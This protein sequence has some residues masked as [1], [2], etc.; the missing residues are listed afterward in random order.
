MPFIDD[1]P[2]DGVPEPPVRPLYGDRFVKALRVAAIA[3]GGQGR[4]SSDATSRPIPY[5]SHPLGVCSIAQ[6]YG[7]DEDEAIAALLHD[8]L[9]DVTPTDAAIRSVRWFGDRVYRIVEDCTDGM[10]GPNGK[11]KPTAERRAAYL[12]RLA[13]ADGSALLVSASDKLHNARSVVADLRVV[14]DDVWRRFNLG[15]EDQL[16]WYRDL[17]RAYRANPAHHVPLVDELARVVQEMRR[18]AEETEL[19]A[20]R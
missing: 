13:A 12:P 19:A 14:G 4:K 6:G 17:V 16:A 11:K 20:A 9:E 8:V 1:L 5:I 15:K 2:F 3:H 10:P 7:A 18:L